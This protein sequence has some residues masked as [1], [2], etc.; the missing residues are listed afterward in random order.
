MSDFPADAD[1]TV[2][3]GGFYGLRL[4]AMSAGAGQSTIVCERDAHFLARASFNNQARVHG[5][6]HY[7]RSVLTA[8]RARQ[9]YARFHEDFGN[10]ILADFQHVYAI[11]RNQSKVRASEFVEFC[12]RIEA[13]LV[14]APRA[15]AELF[16]TSAVEQA[17]VAQETVFNAHTLA[18]LV[19]MWLAAPPY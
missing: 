6:Y 4:A 5:G 8:M 16:D 10:A 17:F 9:H 7:P 18:D 2:I 14:P 12:R 15:I 19:P 11:A 13:P 1:V 3:G